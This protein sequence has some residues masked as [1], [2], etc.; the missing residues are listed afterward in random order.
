MSDESPPSFNH[1]YYIFWKKFFQ[2]QSMSEG[3][4]SSDYESFKNES[5]LIEKQSYSKSNNS[6]NH[7]R[8]PNVFSF[9]QIGRLTSTVTNSSESIINYPIQTIQCSIGQS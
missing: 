1:C 5:I 4:D 6:L 9:R 8:N 3:L 7:Q 2:S